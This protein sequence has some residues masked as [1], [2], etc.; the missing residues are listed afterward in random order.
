MYIL[1]NRRCS[2]CQTRH[3]QNCI[4][5]ILES[6][7]LLLITYII[8]NDT[9]FSTWLCCAILTINSLTDKTIQSMHT[10]F[11]RH[12]ILFD[13]TKHGIAVNYRTW[14]I[15]FYTRVKSSQL[16][17]YERNIFR[18]FETIETVK[19]EMSLN[20]CFE[21]KRNCPSRLIFQTNSH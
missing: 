16:T 8:S 2:E 11:D 12:S 19:E 18:L 5:I 3:K 15:V 10:I 1:P 14:I 7:I 20:T 13:L 9:F 6:N 21:Y 17:A 4:E